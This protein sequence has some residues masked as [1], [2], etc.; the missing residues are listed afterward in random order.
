MQ[1]IQPREDEWFSSGTSEEVAVKRQLLKVIERI[2]GSRL[3]D[4]FLFRNVVRSTYVGGPY[5]R[6][7]IQGNSVLTRM[8]SDLSI[9]FVGTLRK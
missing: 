6:L 3:D 4:D 2:N 9:V 5:T 8:K 7:E 1:R